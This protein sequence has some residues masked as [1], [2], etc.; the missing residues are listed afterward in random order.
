VLGDAGAHVTDGAQPE[1]QD[2]AALRDA[3]VLDGLP[4]GGQ[5]V[6]QVDEAVVERGVGHLDRQRVAERHPQVLGLAAGHLAVELGVAEQR[7]AEALLAVLRGLALGV[8]ALRA[9][10][11]G[12]AGDV[13]RDDDAV[14]GL[15]G[16][17]VGADLADDPHGLVAHDVTQGHE[18]RHDLDQVEVRAADAARGD[19]DDH[20]GGLLDDRV[21]DRVDPYVA[22]AVPGHCAHAVSPSIELE[23]GVVQGLSAPS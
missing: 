21:G 8:Q 7:G 4:G 10:P 11:A 2:A 16:G 9:H 23:F 14:A 5:D 12:V 18:R 1:D 3:G 6:G 15:H 20:V 13:E 19:L 17:H 22:P